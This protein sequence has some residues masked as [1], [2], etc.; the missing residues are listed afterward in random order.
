MDLDAW[1]WIKVSSDETIATLIL[2]ED[3]AHLL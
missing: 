1:A 3:T 2:N